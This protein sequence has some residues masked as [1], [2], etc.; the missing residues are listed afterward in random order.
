[1]LLKDTRLRGM[2]DTALMMRSVGVLASEGFS[3]VIWRR[4]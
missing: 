1:M 3:P 4:E 2:A